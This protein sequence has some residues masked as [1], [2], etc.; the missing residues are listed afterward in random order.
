MSFPSIPT[1]GPKNTANWEALS[2]IL[3]TGKGD[4][5]GKVRGRIGT[6][7]LREDGKA[8]ETLYVKESGE[9]TAEGWEA[10]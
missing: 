8:G 1:E 6:L 9:G 3:I 10:K 5:A 2:Q 4:P 7:Y